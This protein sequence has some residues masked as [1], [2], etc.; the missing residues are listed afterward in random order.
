MRN[1]PGITK[2]KIR[3]KIENI[4]KSFIE[5]DTM[6]NAGLNEDVPTIQEMIIE[7]QS[8]GGR[9]YNCGNIETYR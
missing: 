4:S 8:T 7:E 9:Q 2:H 3:Q 6:V 5:R 1:L